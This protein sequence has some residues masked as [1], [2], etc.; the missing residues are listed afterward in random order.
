MAV[1]DID[2]VAA[3]G[4]LYEGM[5]LIDS[6]KFASQPDAVMQ[7]L[8]ELLDRVGATTVAQRAWQD[9]RLA[10]EVAGHRKGLHYLV[11]FRMAGDAVQELGR[12][13]RLSDYIVR[14]IVI[15]H[16]PTMFEAM[17]N[18][19]DPGSS[20][21]EDATEEAG[22]SAPKEEGKDDKQSQAGED[23]QDN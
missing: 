22:G 8:T 12:L 21:E 3:D 13:C 19:V 4:N 15:R 2:D 14:H 16:D 9:G 6:G 11:Y 7:H 10:Y 1:A 18:A 20:S 5:F 17:V 23:S